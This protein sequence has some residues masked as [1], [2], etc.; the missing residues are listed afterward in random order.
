MLELEW[1]GT[2]KKQRG[3]FMR[4]YRGEVELIRKSRR[5]LMED[6]SAVA[7]FLDARRQQTAGGAIRAAER[8][9][10]EAA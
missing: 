10:Q 6:L 1:K 7:D 9:I 5:E 2:A 8:I 3:A 4:E